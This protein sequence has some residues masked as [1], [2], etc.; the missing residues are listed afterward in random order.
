MKKV[1][2]KQFEEFTP[3]EQATWPLTSE[4]NQRR[5][6]NLQQKRARVEDIKSDDFDSV[7]KDDKVVKQ[8]RKDFCDHCAYCE[9]KL[10]FATSYFPVEHY[11]PKT[12]Y[13]TL[14]NKEEKHP[15]YWWLAYE[16]GNLLL[17]CQVCNAYKSSFFPLVDETKRDIANKNIEKEEPLILSPVDDNPYDHIVFRCEYALAKDGS[18]K[19]QTTINK[20]Q[21]NRP[22]LVNNRLN[23]WLELQKVKKQCEEIIST[24]INSQLRPILEETLSLVV[25]DK[26]QA[27]LTECFTGMFENQI[28]E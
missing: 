4:Q 20:C 3:E 25:E 19:G 21:L 6:T 13:K 28:C 24:C 26:R 2:K 17:S 12:A 8:L 1:K 15:G 22:E 9:S 23:K 14:N 11:R 16:W 5:L 10:D 18:L 27:L 7:Y